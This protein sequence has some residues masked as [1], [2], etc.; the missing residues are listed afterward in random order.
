MAQQVRGGE[1]RRPSIAEQ[2]GAALPSEAD[3]M[4]MTDE[5]VEEMLMKSMMVNELL[6]SELA[7]KEAHEAGG[8]R[9]T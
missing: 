9:S 2:A 6:M 8:T 4:A 1:Q 5:Q 7:A 3:I